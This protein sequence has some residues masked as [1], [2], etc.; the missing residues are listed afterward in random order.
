VSGEHHHGDVRVGAD[1][2]HVAPLAAS[3][4]YVGS[5]LPLFA[6]AK[7][8]KAY[9]G[10]QIEPYLRGR[11]LEV[12]AGLGS[13][14][15]ALCDP[16]RHRWTCLEPDRELARSLAATLAGTERA[17]CCTT[18]AGTVESLRGSNWDTVVYI[19]VLEH[20]ERDRDELATAADLLTP[21]GCL[22]VLSPSHQ[23][24]YS[25]FDRA[26]GHHRRYSRRTLTQVMP[27]GTRVE[28]LRYL[29]SVGLLTSLAN[30]LL[31]RQAVPTLKQ[32]LL[33]DRTL[34]PCSRL[35]DRALGFRIGRSVLCIARKSG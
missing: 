5:E 6:H 15:V 26:V 23:F 8:W 9:W 14:T 12:G 31:L 30:R 10:T 29:D 34:V 32:I 22:V 7:N 19:D 3:L 17:K 27:R 13:N 28:R 35:L 20:I 11:V 2:P 24:L 25:D 16:T 33:W 1:E 18:I 4:T 21:N